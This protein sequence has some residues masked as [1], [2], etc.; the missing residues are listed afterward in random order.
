MSGVQGAGGRGTTC[1]R[2]SQGP[3][4]SSE[5]GRRRV[6]ECVRGAGK[7]WSSGKGCTLVARAPVPV[8]GAV[9]AHRHRPHRRSS[10]P[11]LPCT[12]PLTVRPEALP[13]PTWTPTADLRGASG[14][15]HVGTRG[16]GCARAH[17]CVT[18]CILPQKRKIKYERQCSAPE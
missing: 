4:C 15:L 6:Q 7:G 9:L 14:R 18:R 8:D 12:I 5:V 1:V 16:P 11:P 2:E 10:L 17:A 3:G 13:R